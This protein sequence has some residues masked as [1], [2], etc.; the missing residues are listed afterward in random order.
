M[1][2]A[3][4][5]PVSG[6]GRA[7]GVSKEVETELSR[8]GIECRMLRAESPEDT[9]RLARE[10]AAQ[11]PEGVIAVGGDGSFFDV[12]NGIGVSGVPLLFV[13][14]GTGNDFVKC[15]PLPKDPIEALR[16]QLDAPE[17][18]LDLGR[19][20]DTYFLNVSGT[21]FDVDVLRCVDRHKDRGGGLKPYLLALKDAI[22]DYRPA[23]AAVSFDGEPERRVRF[24]ICS[25]G[26]GRC[27]GGGM[28]AVPGAELDD[29]LFDVVTVAPVPKL[30]IP[31]LIIFYIAGLHVRFGLAHRRRCRRFTLKRENMTVNLDG[32]LR[33]TDVANYELL[34]HALR[35][36][37]PHPPL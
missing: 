10:A 23:E 28:K 18:R 7:L 12:A 14:C 8:R 16:A 4:V 30:L 26:N 34:P 9:R 11:S 20:N 15:L 13:P 1:Y 31:I 25:V 36:K 2:I 19:M 35:V 32:E 3:I 29:G 22:R 24:A 5:N 6:Q 21:G 17:A 33:E 37:L 27:I